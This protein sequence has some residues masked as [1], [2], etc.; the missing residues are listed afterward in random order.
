MKDLNHGHQIDLVVIQPSNF[1]NLD[2][3][4]CYLPNRDDRARMHDAILERAIERVLSSR[5]LGDQLTVVWHAGEPTAVPIAFYERA[6]QLFAQYTP[7]GLSVTQSFQTNGTLISDEWCA[8]IRA[9][10]FKIGVS[11]DGPEFLHDSRRTTRSGKGT[12]KRVMAGVRKLREHGIDYS[13]ICVL[14][15]ESL[16]HPDVIF[17]F[18]YDNGF[19]GVGFNNEEVD[20]V[21]AESSL[22]EIPPDLYRSF[23]T[24]FLERLRAS[25]GRMKIREYELLANFI[26]GTDQFVR[27]TQENTPLSILS[28]DAKGNYSTFSP[29]LLGTR[30][31]EY[32]DFLFGN[33]MTASPDDIPKNPAF[34]KA[35]RDIRAG[36]REC[37][38][39]CPHF[40]VCGGGNPS[41]KIAE[42]GSFRSTETMQ[43]RLSQQ[44]LVDV[45]LG[46]ME[47]MVEGRLGLASQSPR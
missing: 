46:D 28:I 19:I 7:K 1:C 37:R 41:N 33:V 25:D 4:Y 20:G 44:E 31:K 5:S 39:R 42:N 23:H 35:L 11:V 10:D 2:C 47:R 40:G 38:N 21:N 6:M 32:G 12:H 43:C 18:F 17:D 14:S 26:A 24:R 13:A 27:R 16:A 3:A 36:I 30:S 34:R 15:R 8:F 29:E 45:F 9:H 22:G